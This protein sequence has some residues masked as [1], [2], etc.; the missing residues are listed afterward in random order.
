MALLEKGADVY[1]ETSDGNT[2][3]LWACLNGNTGGFIII[4]LKVLPSDAGA[5]ERRGAARQLSNP[6]Q[7]PPTKGRT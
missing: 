6:N 5:Q 3:L 1:A 7:S 4:T 2:P